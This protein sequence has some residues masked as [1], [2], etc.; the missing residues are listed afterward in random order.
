MNVPAPL[1][2]AWRSIK[3]RGYGQGWLNRASRRR[4]EAL[5]PTLGEAQARVVADLRRDGF[6]L[7]DVR[8]LVPDLWPEAAEAGRVFIA[9]ERVRRGIEA[10]R[11]EEGKTRGKDY[12]VKL[13]ELRPSLPASDVWLRIGLAPALLETVNSYLGLWSKLNYVDLWYTI[14]SPVERQAQASQRWH[15]DPEDERLVKVFLYLSDVGAASGPL[16]YVCGSHGDGRWAGLF[17]NPDPGTASYP[18]EGEI[19]LRIP[20][21]DR[22][23]ATGAAGTLVF[24]D[25]YGFHRGGLATEQAR[26]LATWSY[27]T[28]ASIFAR[29]FDAE[30]STDPGGAAGFAVR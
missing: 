15:R 8:E 2:R 26:V 14:P 1:R 29:R 22:V 20:A 23:L 27:V 4:F 10:Y 12:I 5:R 21:A 24:C 28:P 25:T 13:H 30:G 7:A 6:A 19:E 17:P 3:Y 9:S 16:E 11:P 18:P